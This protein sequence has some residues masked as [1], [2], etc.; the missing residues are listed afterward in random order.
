MKPKHGP[1]LDENG[2]A[3]P[4]SSRSNNNAA[5]P[6]WTPRE[7]AQLRLLRLQHPNAS[8]ASIGQQLVP[9]RSG[10]SCRARFA[11][12]PLVEG[13]FAVDVEG[14]GLDAD[15][16]RTG[17]K[18]KRGRPKKSL[19][20]D[21][22]EQ[23]IVV[24]DPPVASTSG[25]SSSSPFDLPVSASGDLVVEQPPVSVLPISTA[26]TVEQATPNDDNPLAGLLDPS[27]MDVDVGA[28]KGKDAE[29]TRQ[30]SPSLNGSDKDVEEQLVAG[31]SKSTKS[32]GKEREN[33][34]SVT[35]TDEQLVSA[36]QAAL[37]PAPID[38]N[39]PSTRSTKR[40]KVGPEDLEA[41][42]RSLGEKV[43]DEITLTTGVLK[44]AIANPWT[45]EEED[46]L[47]ELANGT[48]KRSWAKIANE[49]GTG[50]TAA[51]VS[52]RFQKLNNLQ[53]LSSTR[54]GTST[55]SDPKPNFTGKPWTAQ[56]DEELRAGV[57]RHGKNKWELVGAEMSRP[58]SGQ[59]L[60]SRW[61]DHLADKS[62]RGK[63]S[64]DIPLDENGEASD[65]IQE[66][67]P[68]QAKKRW[69][70][71]EDMQLRQM[72]DLYQPLY[73]AEKEL[74]KHVGEA[75]DGRSGASCRL[76]WLN[77]V[78]KNTSPS[79]LPSNLDPEL[80]KG[81]VDAV[82]SRDHAS[83]LALLGP[84]GSGSAENGDIAVTHESP[85]QIAETAQEFAE[86]RTQEAEIEA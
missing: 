75:M 80:L 22:L 66:S 85:N 12:S 30:R 70:K 29:G 59:A 27:L 58:R 83:L 72:H 35:W 5:N 37:P 33:V 62:E 3:I 44:P 60:V 77:Y 20:D 7:D 2:V 4:P 26:T 51:S 38:I 67:K 82:L 16:A 31:K 68:F 76:R 6:R 73:N 17:E 9:A 40:R 45:K 74:W 48:G 18:R 39:M 50:R 81:G 13:A 42:K 63:K 46:K 41:L 43:F 79:D 55:S 61:Y 86:T 49:L 14:L 28:E 53:E 32:K 15:G 57:N 71:A 8:W 84:E 21:G 69:S 36:A 64:T 19:N 47:M 24:D 23:S 10:G 54:V 34:D 65:V 25:H 1:L 11:Q 52:G 78:E 56:D